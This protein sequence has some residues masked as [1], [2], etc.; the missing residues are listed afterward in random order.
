[1]SAD[2]ASHW[3]LFL[4]SFYLLMEKKGSLWCSFEAEHDARI[5]ETFH[6][7]LSWCL[8]SS[9]L[10]HGDSG[11]CL[12]CGSSLLFAGPQQGTCPS[13]KL[14]NKQFPWGLHPSLSQGW[15]PNHTGPGQKLGWAV[16]TQGQQHQSEWPLPAPVAIKTWGRFLFQKLNGRCF[17]LFYLSSSTKQNAIWK[18]MSL[19]KQ[20]SPLSPWPRHAAEL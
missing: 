16:F 4:G 20:L 6:L 18:S 9:L 15:I 8:P 2:R 3:Y 17:N 11:M 7:P 12:A 13:P 5:T 1:M 14:W 19:C 10:K